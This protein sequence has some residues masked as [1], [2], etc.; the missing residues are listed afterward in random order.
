LRFTSGLLSLLDDPVGALHEL[1]KVTRGVVQAPKNP[2]SD[3][4][5][6]IGGHVELVTGERDTVERVAE[7]VAHPPHSFR[8]VL[9]GVA[10]FM[11]GGPPQSRLDVSRGPSPEQRIH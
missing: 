7:R 11:D 9:R 6:L 1:A 8:L 3:F 2:L 5:Q 4:G 10:Q